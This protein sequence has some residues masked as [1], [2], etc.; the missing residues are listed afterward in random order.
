LLDLAMPGIDG[1]ETLRR[2]RSMEG[3]QPH[4][5]IV[6]ANAFDRGLDNG[7]GISV[8]DFIVKPVRHSELL[9]WLGHRLALQWMDTRPAPAATPAVAS[10]NGAPPPKLEL[11]ALQGLLQLGFYRGILNKL[12]AIAVAHPQTQP[13]IQ[14]T[15]TLARQYRFEEILLQLQGLIE[16]DET[17]EH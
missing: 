5:A 14:A 4:V 1:W 16:A 12:E 2:I 3:L 9:D 7:Q 17:H 8:E 13:W 11:Q 15:A 10:G 6:S